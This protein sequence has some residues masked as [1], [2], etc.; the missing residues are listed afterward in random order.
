MIFRK[1]F[2]VFITAAAKLQ[3]LYLMMVRWLARG[4]LLDRFPRVPSFYIHLI[5]S[6]NS[7]PFHICRFI[8]T[9]CIISHLDH[10]L[11]QIKSKYIYDRKLQI[12][13]IGNFMANL[14]LNS[15]HWFYKRNCSFWRL[16]PC[17]ITGNYTFSFTFRKFCISE[18]V[19]DMALLP[20]QLKLAV[21]G[22][23]WNRVPFKKFH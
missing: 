19:K 16:R 6:L 17:W 10:K 23:H 20:N 4:M 21:T 8:I 9:K 3:F 13:L 15:Q 18:I 11:T 7:F 1:A 14:C 5:L 2:F 12:M 22:S